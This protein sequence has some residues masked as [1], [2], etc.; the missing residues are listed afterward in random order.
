MLEIDGDDV[1]GGG[2]GENR[3]V[4]LF[5]FWH[6]LEEIFVKVRYSRWSVGS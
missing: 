1:D 3:A 5:D 4:T 2:G 6:S